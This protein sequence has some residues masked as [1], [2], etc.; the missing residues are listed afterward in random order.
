LLSLVLSDP[1]LDPASI[2]GVKA[3]RDRL[4]VRLVVETR[5]VDDLPLH[6][7]GKRRTVVSYLAGSKVSPDQA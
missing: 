4:G 7:S 6:G 2:E 1:G 5:M 3:L